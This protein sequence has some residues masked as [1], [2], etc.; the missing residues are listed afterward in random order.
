M[1][2]TWW[3]EKP[4]ELQQFADSNNSHGFY[5]A[6]KKIYGTRRHNSH[7]VKSEYGNT[8]F[9]NNEEFLAKWAEHF[10][11]LLNQVNLTTP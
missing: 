6:A 8:L 10:Y 11:S 7:P 9:K 5:D 1:D 2:N 4:L 3:H